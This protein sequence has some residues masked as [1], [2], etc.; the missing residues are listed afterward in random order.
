MTSATNGTEIFKV[1]FGGRLT[2]GRKENAI[3]TKG[4]FKLPEGVGSHRFSGPE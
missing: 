4:H 1:S 3:T 2:L